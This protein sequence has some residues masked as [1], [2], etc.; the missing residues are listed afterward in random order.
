MTNVHFSIPDTGT[1]PRPLPM[2]CADAAG[3]LYT[4]DTRSLLKN[5]R[6]FIPVMGEFHFSRWDP[7]S[8]REELLKMKAGGIT[9]VATYLFWIHHEERPGEFDFTGRRDIRRFVDLRP[10]SV[11][12]T[13]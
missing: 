11:W 13:P 5:G 10:Q 9:V 3:N 1:A 8:W 12:R 4:V 7:E 6:R 2:G